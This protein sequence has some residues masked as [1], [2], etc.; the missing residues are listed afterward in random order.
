MLF[1]KVKLIALVAT[2]INIYSLS[3]LAEP[4]YMNEYLFW[5]NTNSALELS[6]NDS[7]CLTPKVG[8]FRP[9]VE[10]TSDQF[11][12]FCSYNETA[13]NVVI[14]AWNNAQNCSGPLVGNVLLNV[15]SGVQWVSSNPTNP[16]VL[17]YQ[18]SS[19]VS[20]EIEIDNR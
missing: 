5:D 3:A 13:C 19:P 20:Q 7:A 4:Q 17:S 1:N 16:Y 10:I 2:I 6:I 9:E 8:A 14:H 12:N 15:Y 11:Y 18:T